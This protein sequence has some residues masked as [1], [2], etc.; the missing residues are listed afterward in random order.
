M[1]EHIWTVLCYKGCIDTLT[2]QVSLLDVTEKLKLGIEA[3]ERERMDRTEG[4]MKTPVNLEVV[5]WWVR[6]KPDVPESAKGRLIL[7]SPHGHE[8][9]G[10]GFEINLTVSSGWRGRLLINSF[11]VNQGEGLFWFEVQL[12]EEP[13]TWKM[14]SRVPLEFQLQVVE[15]LDSAT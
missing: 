13:E 9:G 4:V 8:V 3:E 11:P 7:R 5:S 6:S 12:L 15:S 14:V 2:N 1:P 10:G